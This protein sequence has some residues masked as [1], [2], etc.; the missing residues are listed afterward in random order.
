MQETIYD[1]LHILG[2]PP[3]YFDGMGGGGEGPKE[4]FGSE[5]LAK[6]SFAGS[7]KTPGLFG[8]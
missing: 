3:I 7:K 4:F 6:W 2:T 5:I 8:S 1:S